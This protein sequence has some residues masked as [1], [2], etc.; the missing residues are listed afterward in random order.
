MR[1]S[2]PSD[3]SQFGVNVFSDERMRE[4]LEPH[5]Y[6]ALHC[7]LDEGRELPGEVADDVAEAMLHPHGG[8]N[9]GCLFAREL[10][11]HHQGRSISESL[12]ILRRGNGL[13]QLSNRYDGKILPIKAPQI[14]LQIL[15]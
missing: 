10:I 15:P 14:G 9:A 8:E 4:R 7:T 6:A 2:C 1:E 3:L 12:Y 13:P 11:V 5:I